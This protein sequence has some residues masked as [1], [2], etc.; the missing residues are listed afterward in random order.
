[1]TA[2]RRL[3]AILAADVAG[4]SRLMGQ[5]EE[6]THERLRAHLREL[7]EPKIAEHRGRIVK[8]TG[9][10]FLA[11]FASVV[12]AVRCGVEVQRGMAERNGATAPEKGI[13]FRI[14]INL[15]DVIAEEHDIFG[16]GVNVAARL[17]ALAEPGGICVSR[18]VRDQVRDRL[19][20]TFEDRGEQSVKNI[21]RPVRVYALRP[22]AMANL[23][24]VSEPFARSISLPPAAPRLSIVVLPFANLSD[25]RDQQYFADGITED[26]TTDVSRISGLLVISRSTAFTYRHKQI[27]TKRVGRELGV[28]YVLEGSVR[29]SSDHVRVNAQLID[30]ETDAHLW[31]DRF[32]GNTADMFALQDEITRRIAVALNLELIGAEAVR[33]TNV[34]E[35]RDYILRGRSVVE[36][37]PP[38]RHNFAEAIGLFERA[39]SLD[40]SSADA[41]ALLASALAGRVLDGM[42]GSVTDDV[43]RAEELAKRALAI[44]PRSPLAHFSN[45]EVLRAQGQP[46]HAISEYEVAIASNRN[47]VEAI[48]ALGWCKFFAGYVAEV[49]PL[50]EQIIRL[51]PRDPEIGPWYFRIGRVHLVQSRTEEAIAWLE[52]AVRANPDHPLIHAHLASAYALNR[53][54]EQ[55]FAELAEARGLSGDD[56]YKSMAR[57]I[58]AGYWGVP[59]VR[60]LFEGTFFAGLRKAGMPEE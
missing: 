36:L 34:P 11:E 28:C 8:N 60:R 19:D 43:A 54:P 3:T 17:E 21:A 46:Q 7:V 2:V 24:A 38:S 27:E 47:W 48:A 57:L 41:A 16:D 40:P 6:G 39:L 4:Y 55:A 49:I 42:S 59:T 44:S 13:E 15:G 5:D 23:P 29:R 32:D 50:H 10:G 26:L 25:D 53:Q 14:G 18:V 52:K 35:A 58:A 31:A 37:N 22:D 30:A 51:S 12:D 1:M 20:Y 56:R 33:P 45:G 9:D